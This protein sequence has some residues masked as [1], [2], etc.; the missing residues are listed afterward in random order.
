M[1]KNSESA[2]VDDVGEPVA[3]GSDVS[4]SEG[5]GR[6]IVPLVSIPGERREVVADRKRQRVELVSEPV[7]EYQRIS[8][9]QSERRVIRAVDDLDLVAGDG[10]ILSRAEADCRKI[11]LLLR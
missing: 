11:V 3:L 10:Y 9:A 6:L 5:S 2:L 7:A 8:G 4:R 1:D